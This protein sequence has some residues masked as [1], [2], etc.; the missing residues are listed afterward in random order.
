MRGSKKASVN[1]LNKGS[2]PTVSAIRK[3]RSRIRNAKD[4]KTFLFRL[5]ILVAFLGLVFYGVF[6]IYSVP[7]DD[8]KPRISAGDLLLYFRLQRDFIADDIVI[9]QAEGEQHVGRIVAVEND[10]VEIKP[11]GG[12]Y[13][14]ENYKLEK[15]IFYDTCPYEDYVEYPIT[16]EY[17]QYFVLADNREAAVDSRYYGP[18]SENQ[19][20]GKVISLMR[21]GTL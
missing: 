17:G 7:N 2:N 11:E 13:I 19:I 20:V 21:R 3:N 5:I 6:G 14:N 15:E 16:L 8:M 18:V 1:E 10:E 4:I 12:L 9:Y